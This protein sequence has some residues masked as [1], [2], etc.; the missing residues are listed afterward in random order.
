MKAARL[1]LAI[2]G[3]VVVLYGAGWILLH[4]PPAQLVLLGVWLIGLLLIQHGS[5]RPW[6]S[7]WAGRCGGPCPTAAAVTSKR[8]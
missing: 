8:G 1:I 5:S 3:I 2:A 7:P 6:S 4:V